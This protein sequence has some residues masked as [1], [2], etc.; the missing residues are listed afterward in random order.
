MLLWN[1]AVIVQGQMLAEEPLNPYRICWPGLP[2]NA[3]RAVYFAALWS[4]ATDTLHWFKRLRLRKGALQEK[5]DTCATFLPT[6]PGPYTFALLLVKP[7]QRMPARYTL[8]RRTPWTLRAF[9]S[10][11]PMGLALVQ[12]VNFLVVG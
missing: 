4:P 3:D 2:A 7:N 10:Q 8:R 6:P 12:Q 1:G 9:A 11:F 5:A